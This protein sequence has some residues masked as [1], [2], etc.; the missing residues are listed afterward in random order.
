[1][2][3]ADL[4]R[5]WPSDAQ[6]ALIR[7]SSSP[8][9]AW[10]RAS[11]NDWCTRFV[12]RDPAAGAYR[13][14]PA[15]Y[16][17]LLRA[18]V[19]DD[20]MPHLKGVARHCFTAGALNRRLAIEV[21]AKL[22]AAEIPVLA[23]KGL[24]LALACPGEV[25]RPMS[26]IDLLVP[27]QYA[28][29]AV[30]IVAQLGFVPGPHNTFASV[31][32]AI[33]HTHGHGFQRGSSHLDL[34]WQSVHHD[35]NFSFDSPVWQRARAV[36]LHDQVLALPDPT[37]LLLQVVLHGLFYN[38]S[39]IWTWPADMLVVLD[40][41]QGRIDWPRLLEIAQTRRLLVPLRVLLTALDAFAPG[42]VPPDYAHA[43]AAEGVT[44]VELA[45][46][47]GFTGHWTR[48]PQVDLRA[49]DYMIARRRQT[50]GPLEPEP[51]WS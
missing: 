48:A 9:D 1:M 39:H 12:V 42:T 19:N 49:R 20:A 51:A 47:R 40:I 4:H 31:K 45:E 3:D 44:F 25:P 16:R 23:L 50:P 17:R 33:G 11:W 6:Q 14:L 30:D 21:V 41:A 26:D 29:H 18:G 28:H 36:A 37:D 38:A 46:H 35:P 7:I 22:S 24:A 27:P 2:S 10:V 8:D 43:V 15:L 34:H 5:N 13:L 32:A